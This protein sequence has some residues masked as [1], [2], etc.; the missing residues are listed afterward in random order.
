MTTAEQL[1]GNKREDE[2]WRSVWG[3]GQGAMSPPQQKKTDLGE[4][5]EVTFRLPK[6]PS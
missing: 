6:R 3:L 5:G 1:Y 4:A 2:Q